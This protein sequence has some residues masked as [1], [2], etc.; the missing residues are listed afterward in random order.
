VRGTLDTHRPSGASGDHGLQVKGAPRYHPG[1]V[2]TTTV[3]EQVMAA[4]FDVIIAGQISM[5][6]ARTHCHRHRAAVVVTGSDCVRRA[7]IDH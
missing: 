7:L 2:A 5:V 6:P 1:D 3:A 4:N